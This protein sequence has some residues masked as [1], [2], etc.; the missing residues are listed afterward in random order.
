MLCSVLITFGEFATN[1]ARERGAELDLE[2]IEMTIGSIEAETRLLRDNFKMFHDDTISAE[3]AERV[4][5]EA[6]HEA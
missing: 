6:F 4:L 5:M 3:E 2:S 1:L